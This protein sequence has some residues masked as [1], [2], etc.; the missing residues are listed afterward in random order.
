MPFVKPPLRR[1]VL[2]VATMLVTAAVP[3]AANAAGCPTAPTTKP[4]SAFGDLA[5]YTL[6]PAGAFEGGATGWSLS[7]A[8]VVA[9]NET[10]KVHGGADAKSLAIQATGA[11]VTPAFCVSIA[12]PSFRFF[13]RRTS[14]GWGVLNVI[15]RWTDAGG[16]SHDTTAGALTGDGYLSWQPSPML[17]LGRMLP[18]WQPGST[19]PVRLVFDPENYGGSWAIDDLY[20]DPYSR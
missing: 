7:G 2:A 15:V 4:F 20:I 11:A 18:L 19:V 13:A 16:N 17:A 5:D 3:A 8:S 6:A 14:G 1:A 10:Y 9:G 12:E